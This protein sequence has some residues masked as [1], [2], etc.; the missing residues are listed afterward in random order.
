MDKI[1]IHGGIPLT[2]SIQ[3]CGAKNAAL[4]IMVASLLTKDTLILANVPNLADIITMANLLTQHGT[5]I[6]LDGSSQAH[7]KNSGRTMLL[8][9]NNIVSKT[10]PYDIVRKMRA[11]VLVLGPLLARFGEAIVSLPG[12]CAIG[13]RPIDLHLSALEQMGAKIELDNGYIHATVEDRLRGADIHFD[14]VSVGAT[15]NI[16]MAATLASGRTTISNAAREPE[17]TDLIVCLNAMGARI[18][19]I[20][21]N[22]LVI[23]GVE[24]LHGAYHHI[25]SDRIEAGTYAVAAAITGGD[26]ELL[27]IDLKLIENITDKL[28]SSGSIITAT[29]NGVRITRKS[30]SPITPVDITTCAYPGFPTDM[31]AQFMA[32]MAISN[33]AS[34]ISENIFE[35]RFMH[36]PE[37]CRMGANITVKGN[38]ALIRGVT[39]LCGAQIMATDLRASVSLVLLAL[40]CPS[41]TI[42]NRI[43]HIDRG[44]ERI[45]EKLKACGAKIDRI[46]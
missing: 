23:D 11:S 26:L 32:L 34:I 39:E 5:A 41:E 36:V 9:S 10:A 3:I 38:T 4:P 29:K 28:T 14:K 27:N 31:Q 30:G 12:G 40:A 37:L 15:Q 16:V 45:E 25:I 19:G 24:E 2:G 13:S 43:Y 18:T 21:S 46:K 22:Y 35:N 8:G 7:N 44:Y 6:K 20:D 1:R 33:G 17:I 42:I